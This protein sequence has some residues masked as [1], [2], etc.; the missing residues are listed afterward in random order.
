MGNP[1]FFAVRYVYCTV[2]QGMPG[3][4]GKPVK[5][6]KN[7]EEERR[8]KFKINQEPCSSKFVIT[9]AVLLLVLHGNVPE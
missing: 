6:P 4:L 5:I 3:E 9:T 8:E 1:V 2:A 7:Q